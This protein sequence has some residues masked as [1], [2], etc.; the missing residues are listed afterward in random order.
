[1]SRVTVLVVDDDPDQHT[2][3]GVFLEHSGF[4]VLHAFDGQ[5]GVEMAR[6][7]QPALVLMDVRMPRMDGIT[8][9]RALAADPATAHIPVVALSADVLTWPEAR[10]VEEGFA[11]YLPKPCNLERISGLIER[12]TRASAAQGCAAAGPGAMMAV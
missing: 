3:C 6:A 8:A 7:H 1:M 11:G 9:R 2:L 4:A 5:E 12:L 10:V